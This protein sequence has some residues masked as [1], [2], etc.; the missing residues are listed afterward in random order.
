M[1][2]PLVLSDYLHHASLRLKEGGIPTPDLD[3]RLLL[4]A[5]LQKD[6]AFCVLYPDYPLTNQEQKT[7]NL[8][9]ERRLT[10]EPLAKI[11]QQK[12]FWSLPFKTTKD[13]LD[14]R[15]DSET[16]IEA[17][18][19][20]YTDPAASLKILDLGT[21]TGCLLLSLLSEYKNA[22][23]IGVDLSDKALDVARYNAAAL[24]L[25]D[26][27]SFLH[28]NWLENV[29]G[30][31]DIIL[32]NPPYIPPSHSKDLAPELAFDPDMAL[33]TSL[34]DGLC[35]YRILATHITQHLRPHAKIFLEFGK[36]QHKE[37]QNL[38]DSHG[39]QHFTFHK[40]LSNTIRC[41][42]IYKNKI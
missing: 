6:K 16:L 29:E 17:V 4:E 26:R 1:S 30:T 38:F 2:P 34:E 13:T 7:F 12:E 22:T 28:S 41:I 9:L 21:G 40:D 10:R 14:P 15:P 36:G 5:A 27:A 20:K 37:V 24:K 42:C 11:L 18:L 32:S 23:G 19:E 8:S 3:A 35:A 31:F 33:Y 25:K 39:F